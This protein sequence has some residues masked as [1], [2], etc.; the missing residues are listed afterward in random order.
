MLAYC[1]AGQFLARGHPP[2]ERPRRRWKWR[3][4]PFVALAAIRLL[5]ANECRSKSGRQEQRARLPRQGLRFGAELPVGREIHPVLARCFAFRSFL[6]R[7]WSSQF[8][9]SMSLVFLYFTL[10]LAQGRPRI[11]LGR[12]RDRAAGE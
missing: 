12:Q 2:E 9:R 7:E 5:L 11:V 4:L 3:L 1:R 8:P 10:K 6:V